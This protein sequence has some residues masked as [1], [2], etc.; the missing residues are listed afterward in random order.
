MRLVSTNPFHIRYCGLVPSPSRLRTFASALLVTSAL[1]L[2]ACTSARPQ[3]KPTD[4][5]WLATKLY[6]IRSSQF[7]DDGQAGSTPLAEICQAAQR[8]EDVSKAVPYLLEFLESNTNSAIFARQTL[9]HLAKNGADL[10]WYIPA[11][12]MHTTYYS[13][14][15]VWDAIA[16][17]I[18]NDNTR[19]RALDV[20]SE[21]L[22]SH[23]APILNPMMYRQTLLFLVYCAGK[24]VDISPLRP[25]LSDIYLNDDSPFK[26]EARLVLEASKQ[27]NQNLR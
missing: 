23:T 20:F 9:L 7:Y 15:G 2:P 1:A 13:D 19:Q 21:T 27:N 14:G 6:Q 16:Y 12:L 11:L 4:E 17:L 3:L 24:N 22:T 10:T 8:G 25:A 26:V 18:K 5:V